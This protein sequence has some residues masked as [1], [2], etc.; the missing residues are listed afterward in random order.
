MM[1]SRI[2]SLKR[3]AGVRA[4]VSGVVLLSG[5]YCLLG[6]VSPAAAQPF[7][8]TRAFA[9]VA[10]GVNPGFVVTG[11]QGQDGPT[12]SNAALSNFSTAYPNGTFTA[13]A[14]A[15][16]RGFFSTGTYASGQVLNAS[17]P[18]SPPSAGQLDPAFGYVVLGGMGSFTQH[19]FVTPE[20]LTGVFGQFHW[21]VDGTSSTN[22]G[23]ASSRLD[24]AVTQGA[25][26]F[27]DLYN[28]TITP[29]IMTQIG[30]G[31]YTYTTGIALDTP[32]DFLFWSSAFWNVL[33]SDLATLG[34]GTKTI[35]GQA[36]FMNTFN[37]DSI[38]L[39]KADG[40][41][42]ADWQLLDEA[43]GQTIFT[44]SG[45]VQAE[46]AAPEPSSVLLFLAGG[47]AGTGFLSR[48]R[49]VRAAQV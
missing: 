3:A 18:T 19:R 23:L 43:T 4:A 38:D 26:S 49:G 28:S 35:F 8:R 1:F 22:L 27:N 44:Q 21:H 42:I 47:L 16:Y 34:S 30:P 9:G 7:F 32:L 41:K 12:P 14:A 20:S 24:F 10:D 37:L 31:T 40:S 13:S 45:R 17:Y 46:T 25:T 2:Q 6:I 33:P 15:N 36:E 48:R 11:T 39:Y 29:N 5:V